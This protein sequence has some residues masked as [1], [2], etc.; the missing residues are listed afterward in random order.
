[1]T[2][3]T[4]EPLEDSEIQAIVERDRLRDNP[5]PSPPSGV[6]GA[7]QVIRDV[8]KTGPKAGVEVERE[9]FEHIAM[10]LLNAP[11]WLDDEGH[12]KDRRTADLWTAYRAGF[13]AARAT[14]REEK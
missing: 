5:I 9:G 10:N 11:I 3:K 8:L 2:D 4:N 13:G 7:E 1:M 14:R 6:E 12:Y